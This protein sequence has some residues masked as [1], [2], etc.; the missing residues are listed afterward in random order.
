MLWLTSQI[1]A[2]IA[3]HVI[4]CHWPQA[5]GFK[6]RGSECVSTTWQTI[7][8]WPNQSP[9]PLS[10]LPKPHEP[11]PFR[12]ARGGVGHHAGVAH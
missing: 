6:K 4:G 11:E 7:S 1:L 5:Q 8:A 12:A 9:V 2:D 3:A 10:L